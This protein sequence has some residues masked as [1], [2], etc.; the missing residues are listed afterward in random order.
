MYSVYV[1]TY[2]RHSPNLLHI[3]TAGRL[4][5][6][7][8]ETYPTSKQQPGVIVGTTLAMLDSDQYA[9]RCDLPE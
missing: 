4:L 9:G 3:E 2:L 6:H 8:I 7:T 5:S 1:F